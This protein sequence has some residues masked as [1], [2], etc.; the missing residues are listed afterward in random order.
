MK[1]TKNYNYFNTILNL[2][3]PNKHLRW[4]EKQLQPQRKEK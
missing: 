2:I 4:H 3:K 1:Y